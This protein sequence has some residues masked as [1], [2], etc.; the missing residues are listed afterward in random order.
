MSTQVSSRRNL[1]SEATVFWLLV[2]AG[3]IF[4]T[5]FPIR[6]VVAVSGII[7]A[8]LY[9]FVGYFAWK[10]IKWAFIA[11]TVLGVVTLLGTFFL[12]FST[13]ANSSPFLFLSQQAYLFIPEYLLIFSAIRTYRGSFGIRI[14]DREK[15][16]NSSQGSHK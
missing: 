1:D 7:F 14:V 16:V 10:M 8:V 13:T 2:S 3:I 5:S 4:T 12:D 6:D 9:C 15:P 11:A